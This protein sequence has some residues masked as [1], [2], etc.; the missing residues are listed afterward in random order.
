MAAAGAAAGG[1][2]VAPLPA[3]ASTSAFVIRP[4]RAVPLI[5]PRSTPSRAATRRARG[6]ALAPPS[7]S[8]PLSPTMEDFGPLTPSGDAAPES[9]AAEGAPAGLGSGATLA[10]SP[11]CIPPTTWPTVTVSPSP[12][13]I[14]VIVPGTGAGTSASTLSV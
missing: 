1:V 4:P 2:A 10:G 8:G 9:G 3:A 7:V 13:R 12:N 11:A 14:L 6:D 5:P